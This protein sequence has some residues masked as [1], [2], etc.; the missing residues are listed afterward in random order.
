VNC[1]HR[2]TQTDARWSR[3]ISIFKG[4]LYT[5][6]G[7]MGELGTVGL[8]HNKRICLL[9]V[10]VCSSTIEVEK[11][12]NKRHGCRKD[13]L[14]CA[15]EMMKSREDLRLCPFEF[16]LLFF[17]SPFQFN[18][19]SLPVS[20]LALPAFLLSLATCLACLP[21]CSLSCFLPCWAACLP[22]PSFISCDCE[23]M[24]TVKN[25]FSFSPSLAKELNI[26]LCSVCSRAF[27]LKDV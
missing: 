9:H 17:L 23:R 11:C 3:S 16:A 6:L 15:K 27:P 10:C 19:A 14:E 4:N 25:C 2:H 13:M 8:R 7:V 20:S 22:L 21:P 24:L 1:R 12:L 26:S 18:P 5:S